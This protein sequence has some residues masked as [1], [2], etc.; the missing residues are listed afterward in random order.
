MSILPVYWWFRTTQKI[1]LIC[2]KYGSMPYILLHFANSILCQ[3]QFILGHTKDRT[4]NITVLGFVTL[5]GFRI[6]R[7]PMIID[8][9][10]PMGHK[11]ISSC[12]FPKVLQYKRT[13]KN[14]FGSIDLHFMFCVSRFYW[15]LHLFRGHNLMYLPFA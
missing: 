15:W 12:F 14:V 4:T 9:S 8:L 10:K 3:T 11:F 7:N 13:I 6:L 1:F 2:L 5:N